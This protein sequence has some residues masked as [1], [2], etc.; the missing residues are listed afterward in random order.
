MGGGRQ[1][2]Q[3][4]LGQW[5]WQQQ[6]LSCQGGWQQRQLLGLGLHPL[7]SAPAP[8]GRT[9]WCCSHCQCHWWCCCCCHPRGQVAAGL[10]RQPAAAGPHWAAAP[11]ARGVGERHP[12]RPLPL[13]LP[14]PAQPHCCSS[15]P[16][17]PPLLLLPAQQLPQPAPPPPPLLS[18]WPGA[19]PLPSGAAALRAGRGSGAARPRAQPPWLLPPGQ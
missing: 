8:H 1:R 6:G 15:P 18:A 4:W 11:A 19:S 17:P 7:A 5:Q 13:P 2:Q 3:Q 12:P 14:L 9:H 16:P 10:W